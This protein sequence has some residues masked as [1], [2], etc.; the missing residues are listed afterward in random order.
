MAGTLKRPG[1][2]HS[3]TQ[4]RRRHHVREP[5]YSSARPNQTPQTLPRLSALPARRRR[6][7]RR[8][9][10]GRL[11]YFGPWDDPDAALAKYLAEKDDLRKTRP[12]APDADAVTV[13]DA[14]NA[15][16]NA[17]QAAVDSGELSPRTWQDYKDMCDLVVS[18]FGKGRVVSDLHQDDFAALRNKLAKK[19]GPHRTRLGD[20]GCPLSVPVCL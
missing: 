9:S 20:P 19:W 15:F 17:K 10:A 16:L 18:H 4:V 13:K 8:R 6:A 7:E 3:D 11:H 2:E 14:A 12:A 1:R 5:F